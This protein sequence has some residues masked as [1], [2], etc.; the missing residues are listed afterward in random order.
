ME[1][2]TLDAD[3]QPTNPSPTPDGEPAPQEDIGSIEDKTGMITQI[4]IPVCIT[5]ILVIAIVKTVNVQG[6]AVSQAL[7][8]AENPN[9]AGS[10]R[11]FGSLLNALIFVAMIIVVTVIFVVL[12]KYRCLKLI[13]GWL[14][15]STGTMLGFF[16]GYLTYQILSAL[17]I[18]MDWLT[19]SIVIWNFTV[20]GNISIFWHSNMKVNQTYL[21]CI[22]VILAVVFS[23]LPE[24]TTWT[25][26]AAIAIYDL[27]AVLCPRGPLRVLVETAQE[28]D[29]PIPALIYNA[30]I[31]M[32]MVNSDEED[33]QEE[34]KKPTATSTNINTQKEKK[35]DDSSS[36]DKPKG[37]GVKL[38]L[39]DFV[40]YSV[41]VGRAA[42]FDMLTVFS[43][44][45][46]IVTGLFCTI[47]LL[48]LWRKAL[49]ALPISIAFGILFYFLSKIFLYPFATKLIVNGLIV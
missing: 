1:E 20:V 27:F 24:W 15:L 44:F 25:I 42:L 16:G 23:R 28:R 34:D 14:I 19:F 8:Y 41:L 38:G 40:F 43:S 7:V 6:D 47:L 32:M 45:I 49:P 18:P 26:L 2:V 9:D 30:S 10:T 31:V 37:R 17:N 4:M 12:Y 13:F 39:G 46:G 11:F 3:D 48:A 21:I 29:E 35:E 5:M 36:D 22:S 33:S